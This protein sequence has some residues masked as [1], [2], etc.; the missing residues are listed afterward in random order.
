MN[1]LLL[2]FEVYMLTQSLYTISLCTFINKKNSNH[3]KK[4]RI[5]HTKP[6]YLNKE[7]FEYFVPPKGGI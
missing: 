4:S 3:T 5:K 2:H 7:V 1:K 6:H